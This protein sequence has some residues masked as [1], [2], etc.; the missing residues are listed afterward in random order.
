MEMPVELTMLGLT[1]VWLFVL[2]NATALL[3]IGQHS[4]P[5]LVGP[6]DDLPAPNKL[7]G[8]GK[9]AVDNLREGLLLF[10]PF[11]LIG[12]VTSGFDAMTAMGA[13]IF[14]YARVA[15]GLLY[16]AGVPWLRTIVWMVGIV[17]TI[18]VAWP[19]FF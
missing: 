5:I 8:R 2:I 7:V 10:A 19:V 12:A 14:F 1:V 3:S 18:M 9:R 13:M 16:F 6:R 11:V 15:H 4:I 17:G